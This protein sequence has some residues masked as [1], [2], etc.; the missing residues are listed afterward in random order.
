MTRFVRKLSRLLP[1]NEDDPVKKQFKTNIFLVVGIIILMVISGLVTFFLTLEGQ[2]QTLVPDVR[3]VDLAE[4][5]IKLQEKGLNAQV[6]LRY[7]SNPGDKGIILDQDPSP[8]TLVKVGRRVN[9]R[10]SRGAVID[11][12]DNYIGWNIDNLEMHLQTLFTAYDALLRIKKPYIG[13]YS[14]TPKGTILEQKP[15]PETQ[16][17]GPTQLELVVSLGPQGESVMIK[18][19]MERSYLDVLSEVVRDETPFAF[20]VRDASRGE[21]PGIIVSQIPSAESY[22]PAGTLIQ[23]IMTKPSGIPEGKVFGLVQKTLPEYPIPVTLRVEV[24]SPEEGTVSELFSMR[25]KGGLLTIPYVEDINSII[26][27]SLGDSELFRQIIRP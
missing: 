3:S 4:G 11:K 12:V 23:F 21:R 19:Y 6:Q 17:T 14:D 10:V 25:H 22:V 7:S 8:G 20:T 26:I 1:N 24:L 2:E 27:V 15:L 18:N 13:V 9:V 16:I 5:M